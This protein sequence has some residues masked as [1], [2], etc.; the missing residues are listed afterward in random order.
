MLAFL[1]WNPGTQ[2]EIFSL[3]ELVSSFSLDRVSKAGAKFDP[4]KTTWFQQQYLRST[5]DDK[6]AEML[7][8]EISVDCSIERL[9]HM[10]GLMKERATFIKDIWTEGAFLLEQPE[11]Y[12]EKTTRKKWKGDAEKIMLGW[13][14]EL[15]SISTFTATEVEAAFKSYLEKSDLGLGA[16]LP[17]FRLLITGKG[18]GPSMFDISEFLGKEECIARIKNGIDAM[19]KPMPNH[20]KHNRG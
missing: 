9:S 10:C 1:G 13:A 14:E 3:N 12:D 6:L 19:Q 15:N 11:A 5:S 8:K 17:I 4:D 16:V 2:Q 20:E 7:A 18:T